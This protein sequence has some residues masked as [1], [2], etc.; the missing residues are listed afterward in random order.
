MR[1]LGTSRVADYWDHLIVS[2]PARPAFTLASALPRAAVQPAG[3]FCVIRALT[4]LLTPL[5]LWLGGQAASDGPRF[6]IAVVAAALLQKR[7]AIIHAGCAP[8]SSFVGV[9]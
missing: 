6:H 8:P 1:E 7:W 3:P 4:G 2:R 5:F 9:A